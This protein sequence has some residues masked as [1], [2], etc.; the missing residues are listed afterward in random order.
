[1][2][3][4]TCI[5]TIPYQYG[6]AGLCSIDGYLYRWPVTG[7]T[8]GCRARRLFNRGGGVLRTAACQMETYCKYKRPRKD[9]SGTCSATEY[10]GT[11]MR[12]PLRFQH[13]RSNDI[14]AYVTDETIGSNV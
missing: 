3:P 5:D 9:V 1:M 4:V 13:L 8:D 2:V 7:D 11:P 12:K 10:H 14:Y 6:I